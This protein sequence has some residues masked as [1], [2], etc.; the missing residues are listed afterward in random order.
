MED[1]AHRGRRGVERRQGGVRIRRRLAYGDSSMD[2]DCFGP[3]LNARRRRSNGERARAAERSKLPE[4]L[5]REEL[6]E[7]PR[8]CTGLECGTNTAGDE[9][10]QR[11]IR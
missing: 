3:Y 6:G 8:L 4:R 2:D 5:W 11:V 1:L 9:V 7:C 10:G